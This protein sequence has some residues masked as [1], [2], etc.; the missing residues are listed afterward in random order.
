MDTFFN[1]VIQ[2]FL[3]TTAHTGHVKLLEKPRNIFSGPML[4]SN[5]EIVQRQNDSDIYIIWLGIDELHRVLYW[6]EWITLR[7]L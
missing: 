6:S 2:G 5:T 4:C 3:A 1:L 7:I